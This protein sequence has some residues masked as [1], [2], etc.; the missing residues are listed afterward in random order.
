MTSKSHTEVVSKVVLVLMV[1]LGAIMVWFA[2]PA[3]ARSAAVR[4]ARPAARQLTAS[5]AS[6]GSA[7]RRPAFEQQQLQAAGQQGREGEAAVETEGSSLFPSEAHVTVPRATLKENI[8]LIGDVHGCKATLDRLLAQYGYSAR[9]ESTS[10][11][12][13][14]DVVNKGPESLAVLRFVR[15]SGALCV[16][17]NHEHSALQRALRPVAFKSPDTSPVRLVVLVLVLVVQLV[18]KVSRVLGGW[19][20]VKML[21]CCLPAS[22]DSGAAHRR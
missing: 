12:F 10:L 18:A 22:A 21:H 17:G 5:P 4:A 19:F 8:L 13:V 15:S 20:F 16:R 11:V 2:A 6:R 1:G 3:R 14:G 7:R 9:A